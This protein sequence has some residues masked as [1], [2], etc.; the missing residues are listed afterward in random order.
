M[1]H[2]HELPCNNVSVIVSYNRARF[3]F[4]SGEVW[5]VRMLLPAQE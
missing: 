1:L 4:L 3:L 5:I 2:F